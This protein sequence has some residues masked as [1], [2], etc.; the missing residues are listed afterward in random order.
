MGW[1]RLAVDAHLP[2]TNTAL[3]VRLTA[4]EPDPRGRVRARAHAARKGFESTMASFEGR[5]SLTYKAV[6]VD[7]WSGK[8]RGTVSLALSGAPT[9]ANRG[10]QCTR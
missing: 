5:S 4:V 3:H 6:Y 1:Y 8:R 9:A 10:R 7:G 2:A